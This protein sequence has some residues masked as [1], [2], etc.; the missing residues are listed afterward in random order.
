[1][2]AAQA[3]NLWNPYRHLLLLELHGKTDFHRHTQSR[4]ESDHTNC[5]GMAGSV[6]SWRLANTITKPQDSPRNITKM[7]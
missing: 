1:M 4:E 5:V 2:D 3:K 7:W 6:L